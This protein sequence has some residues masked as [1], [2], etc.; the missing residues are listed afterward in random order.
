MTHDRREFLNTF[1]SLGFGT[2][3]I[4]AE[5]LFPDEAYAYRMTDSVS[6]KRRKRS[7]RKDTKFIVLHTTEANG[8]SSL[9]NLTRDGKASYMIDTNGKVY[10]I[11]NPDQISIGCGRSMWDGRRNL[12]NW[13]INIE[14]VGRHNTRP[15]ASQYSSL[16]DLVQDLQKTY[17]ISDRN[18]MPH[19]QVAYGRPN[20]WHR[21]SHRGRKRCGMLFATDSVRERLGLSSKQ[22]DDPDVEEG[23]LMVADPYLRQV[24]YGRAVPEREPDAV[25][26]E[27]DED[28]HILRIVERGQTV[29]R[30]AG[31]EFDAETTIYMLPDGRVR[32]GEELQKAGY[33]FS[34]VPP[35]VQMAVGYVYGGHVHPGRSAYEIAG[36]DWNN[37]STLYRL[38]DRRIIT[39]DDLDSRAIP[40]GTLVLFRK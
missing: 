26:E 22:R 32:T 35:G 4:G 21:R 3:L 13:A 2:A 7:N 40:D 39:G 20:K 12:D 6:P 37:P 15:T 10:K 34:R 17:D 24:I 9:N 28:K 29:W 14:V 31:D 27:V 25:K 33:D 1:A 11:M 23:R 38:P 16:R 19:S 8:S 18:V 5:L 36:R 30:Y